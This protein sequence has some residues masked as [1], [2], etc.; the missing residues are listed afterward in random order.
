VTFTISFTF[1]QPLNF[2]ERRNVK[3]L[4]VNTVLGSRLSDIF[5]FEQFTV[6]SIIDILAFNLFEVSFSINSLDACHE[7]F[8]A[9]DVIYL[10]ISSVA[11]RFSRLFVAGV[12][13]IPTT[14]SY[15]EIC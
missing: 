8:T 1:L 13:K 11:T 9:C 15:Y 7:C 12:M 10:S 14:C 3:L 6:I 2:D 5:G 4:T